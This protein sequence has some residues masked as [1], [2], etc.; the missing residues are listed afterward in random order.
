MAQ[1]CVKHKIVQADT[2]IL[3]KFGTTAARELI[4][5]FLV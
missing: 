3:G 4:K 1:E 5:I 2:E